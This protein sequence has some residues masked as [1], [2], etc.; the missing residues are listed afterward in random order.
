[1]SFS[2]KELKKD[3]ERILNIQMVPTLLNVICETTGMGFAAIARVTTNKW[4]TCYA[5][6]DINFGLVTG[7]EL[8]I[9]TTICNEI[10]DS[11]QPVVIDS[12]KDDQDYCRHHT[13][14]KYGFQSYISYPIFL[15]SG[16]FF[17]TLCA[18]D[19]RPHKLRNTSITGM[20]KAFSE[21]ISF[22]LQQDEQI[23]G[24]QQTIRELNRDLVNSQDE[25]R[26]YQHVSSHTLQEPLRKLQLFTGMLSDA[27]EVNDIEKAKLFAS[28]IKRGSE[29]FSA[30]IGDLT[31][32][33][34]LNNNKPDLLPADLNKIVDQVQ[35]RFL[36]Q[37]QQKSASVVIE[38]LP[39][40]PVYADQIVQL[41]HHIFDN[42]IKF[43]RK[44]VPLKVVVSCRLY[45]GR[46]SNV[47][48]SADKE[49]VE[50]HVADNGIGIEEKQLERIFDI[51]SQ[52]PSEIF[53]EG[54]GTGLAL[55][56]K[57]VRNHF[58]EINI[59][60]KIRQG[61]TVVIILPRS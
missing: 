27:L 12:V 61:T 36:Q 13:P 17:G 51:Y 1:M 2:D 6:D 31:E 14:L 26:Q 5:R 49:Y 43:A 44:D 55:G 19:P 11:H 54:L 18:I 33:S 21:L 46:F 41:F 48:L 37:L 32:F 56:K 4:I 29:R 40:I 3:V 39:I 10:R 22:Y 52:L 42:A 24:N 53:T 15:Q 57:I 50:I 35:Q 47:Q 59:T 9:A 23:K 30:L 38:K 20:F 8:E 45:T 16:V 58:G 34:N 60:S 7:S 28:R 25:N